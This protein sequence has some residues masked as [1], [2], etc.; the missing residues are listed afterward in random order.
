MFFEW[1]NV[2]FRKWKKSQAIFATGRTDVLLVCGGIVESDV[3]EKLPNR[4]SIVA[5]I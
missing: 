1:F 2:S 5:R 3:V 4:M